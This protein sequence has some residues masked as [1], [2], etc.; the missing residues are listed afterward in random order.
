M[1][2]RPA[3]PAR[4]QRPIAIRRNQGKQL[5]GYPGIAFVEVKGVVVHEG[6]RELVQVYS[7]FDE[8]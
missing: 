5:R 3:H 6:G 8:V 2:L 4:F 7:A 1:Y